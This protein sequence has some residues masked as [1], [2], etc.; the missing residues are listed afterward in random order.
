MHVNINFMEY[1]II[2]TVA[3]RYMY[4]YM[5]TLSRLEVVGYSNSTEP[6]SVQLRLPQSRVLQFN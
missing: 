2:T 3:L 4:M 1:Q 5:Y 6:T